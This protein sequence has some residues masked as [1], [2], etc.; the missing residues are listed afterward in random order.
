MSRKNIV[1]ALL[2]FILACTSVTEDRRFSRSLASRDLCETSF[3]C[4]S[5]RVRIHISLIKPVQQF[6]VS[7]TGRCTSTLKYVICSTAD[8]PIFL[9]SSINIM[10]VEY[11]TSYCTTF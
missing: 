4:N 9:M 1:L 7:S 8:T 3:S 11:C 10:H 5:F 6:F 2:D